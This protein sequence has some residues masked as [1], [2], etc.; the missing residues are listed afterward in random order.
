MIRTLAACMLGGLFV[1]ACAENETSTVVTETRTDSTATTAATTTEVAAPEP[2]PSTASSEPQASGDV[3]GAYFAMEPLSGEF[4]E[5]DHL[6]L[7]LIDEN[8]APAPLNG[9]LRPKKQSAKDYT[10]VNP[11]MNG[12]QLTFSTIDVKGVQYDF[13]GAFEVLGNFPENPPSYETVV[14]SGTLNKKRNGA[15]VG[16]LPV[17]FRYEAGG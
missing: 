8:G 11:V 13:E 3:T 15:Q 1:V 12:K 6:M 7:A 2:T 9:F 17:K 16:T 14:L 5:L 10:L 4:A